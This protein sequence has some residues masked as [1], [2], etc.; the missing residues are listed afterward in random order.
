MKLYCAISPLR[1]FLFRVSGE[2]STSANRPLPVSLAATSEA[3]SCF[4]HPSKSVNFNHENWQIT[5]VWHS[6]G[7][8][9]HL[10]GRQP[11]R[12]LSSKMLSNDGYEALERAQ[13]RA[14]NDDR[15]RGWFVGI[16]CVLSGAILQVEALRQLEVKL[17]SGTLERAIQR[18]LDRD[19][20]LR[21]VESAVA[22]VDLPL[23]RV[24]F[25]EGLGEL[26]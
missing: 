15:A 10:P 25:I 14:V 12:P 6:N 22:R 7:N 20:N 4:M 1:I 26:L 17:D 21:T 8:D 24:L 13:D 2:L 23:A 3:Y 16:L 9:K 18:I 5:H 19:I 11:K